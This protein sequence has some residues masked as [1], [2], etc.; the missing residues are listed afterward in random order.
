MIFGSILA[1]PGG[2]M[3]DKPQVLSSELTVPSKRARKR[4]SERARER[5]SERVRE[6][7]SERAREHWRSR[8]KARQRQT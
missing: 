3:I 1:D 6:R 4:E 7:V 5:E 2:N 8:A